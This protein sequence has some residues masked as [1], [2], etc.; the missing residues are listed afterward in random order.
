MDSTADSLRISA[1]AGSAPDPITATVGTGPAMIP[2]ALATSP[3]SAPSTIPAEIPSEIP[4]ESS[5]NVQPNVQPNDP[6]NLA[7]HSS[8]D[9]RLSAA[10][11]E[12]W[13]TA[14]YAG[15]FRYAYRL[16]GQ[17][18][19]AEDLTQQT[20][21]IALR[22]GGNVRAAGAVRSWLLKVCRRQFVR[23]LRHDGLIASGLETNHLPAKESNATRELET[24]DALQAGIDALPGEYRVVVLMFYFEDASYQEIA[25]EL[26]V[27]VGTVMSRLS[28]AKARLRSAFGPADAKDLA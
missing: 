19:T 1:S 20:F 9:A 21:E 26:R 10:A 7:T 6:E 17:S 22:Q 3:L 16:S 25:D 5:P 4:A 12:A 11:L 14:H 13:F 28:R 27:P 18:A 24:R 23:S 2:V 8:S 15:V